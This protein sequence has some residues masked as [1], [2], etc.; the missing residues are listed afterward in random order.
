[1]LLT[2]GAAP[3]DIVT[4]NGYTIQNCGIFASQVQK[5]L[6]NLHNVLQPAI[7]DTHYGV[8]SAPYQA[9]F[10][11]S[12]YE[13]FV[14]H[15][16]S[17][18]SIGS[19]VFLDD[20]KELV[21]PNLVCALKPGIVIAYEAGQV[22]DIYDLCK[23]NPTWV[24]LYYP[25]T[26]TIFICPYFFLMPTV[27]AAGICPV[28]NETTNRFEGDLNALWKSQVYMLLHEIVHFYLGTT[29]EMSANEIVDWNYAYS[30]PARDATLNAFNYVLYVACKYDCISNHRSAFQRLVLRRR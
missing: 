20:T 25:G 8:A 7:W 26:S 17:S 2:I 3:N 5:A 4:S 12:L 29:V 19:A 15:A 9:F 16:L 28:V 30:L 27:P 14:G 13:T 24:V 11:S 22:F 10:K 21:T 23:T 6:S 18:I 1:M